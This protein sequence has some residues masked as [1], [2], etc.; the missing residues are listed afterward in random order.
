[1]N[2]LI[3]HQKKIRLLFSSTLSLFQYTRATTL[4]VIIPIVDSFHPSFHRPKSTTFIRRNAMRMAADLL[5]IGFTGRFFV[6]NS[7]SHLEGMSHM[8]IIHTLSHLPTA[9]F[10]QP[11]HFIL[12]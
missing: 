4:E 3:R 1:M 2:L 10:S 7:I 9:T 5:V 12:A 6:K 8:Q 11:I